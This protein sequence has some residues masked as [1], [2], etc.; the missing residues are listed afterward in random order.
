M[1]S[2]FRFS[3]K[4]ALR[5]LW[6]RR[7][8]AFITIIT[9]ISV[10]GVAIGVMVLNMTMAIMS[11]FENELRKKIVGSA[12]IQVLQLGG[13]VGQWREAARVIEEV[14]DVVSV[15][16][17]TQNQA[18]ISLDGRS[19]GIL[20][21]GILTESTAARELQKYIE[22]G[23]SLD[24][25]LQPQTM[26]V[27][28]ADGKRQQAELPPLIIGREL[29]RSLSVFVGE[30]ISLLSPQVGSSPFGLVPRFKRF[31][32]TGI[33]KSGMAGYE[34]SLA[35]TSLKSSQQFFRMGDAVTGLEVMIG[36]ID[37]APVIARMIRERLN[38][39]PGGR[40]YVQDWT[41]QNKELWE[42][43]ALEKQAYFI[44]LL[45]LIVLAS[46][47]IISA[48]IMIV[49]EKRKDIAV[50]RTLG[51]TT[52]SVGNIFR[53][54][55]AI[56]G[57]LGTLLGT[58]G[59]YLGAIGLREYGFKLPEN[60]FPTSTVPVQLD[61]VN[62]AAVAAAAFFICLVSTIYP[63]RRASKLSPSE[64]LRYE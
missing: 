14:R 7:S 10:L 17:F 6:S 63:A 29:S 32:V 59:G 64:V 37:A 12:H 34:E 16:P 49:I 46:F 31:L 21:R 5:Y 1:A 48:L 22:G 18:L 23:A 3:R 40:F 47:T 20:I 19:R 45:L 57:A 13:A 30:P 60:V 35:Y 25:L 15:S 11:G 41:E 54:Q 58:L 24:D 8:E 52:R 56:I 38:S 55:G 28:A 9:V 2:S 33:Y 42:A 39:L 36:D 53:I 50:M 51:A 4:V 61:W 44:V 26:E 43:L 62:F 27:F